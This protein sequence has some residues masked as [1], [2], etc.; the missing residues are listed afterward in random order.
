MIMHFE[1]PKQ[2][3]KLLMQNQSN[4]PYGIEQTLDN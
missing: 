3:M 1:Y 4:M 2:A